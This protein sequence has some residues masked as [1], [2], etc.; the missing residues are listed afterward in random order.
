MSTVSKW[1]MALIIAAVIVAVLRNAA[2]AVGIIVGGGA[3]LDQIL[4]TLEGGT[5]N[6]NN[7]GKFKVGSNKIELG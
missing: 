5:K 4:G 2:G 1:V 3:E 6:L 7:K